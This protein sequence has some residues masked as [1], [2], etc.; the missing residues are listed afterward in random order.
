MIKAGR[1]KIDERTLMEGVIRRRGLAE[2]A[3]ERTKTARRE[4]HRATRLN[5]KVSVEV[6]EEVPVKPMRTTPADD[7][8]AEPPPVFT[9][10]PNTNVR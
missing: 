10:R 3:R 2:N 4:H 9:I 7:I 5:A 8:F 6:P 1:A